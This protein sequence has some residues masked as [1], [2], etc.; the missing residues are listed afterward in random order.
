MSALVR[1][2][3]VA[4][5]VLLFVACAI[6]A[7][8]AAAQDPRSGVVQSAARAWLELVDKGDPDPS[9]NASGPKFK[10]AYPLGKWREALAL[11]RTPMGTF[12]SRAAIATTFNKDAPDLPP[13]EYANVQFR[14]N[15]SNKIDAHES[16]SLE[17]VADGTWVVIGYALN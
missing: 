6:S 4:A 1:S 3:R 2:I 5:G 13:G 15:F 7:L 16:I 11:Y 8:P 12:E 17:R 14:T 9:W 10:E